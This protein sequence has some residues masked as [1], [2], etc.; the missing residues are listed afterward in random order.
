MKECCENCYFGLDEGKKY[1][2]C[3]RYPPQYET[4]DNWDPSKIKDRNTWC[5]EY[6]LPKNEEE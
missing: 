6:K 4:W 3:R 1:I 5:G 2:I